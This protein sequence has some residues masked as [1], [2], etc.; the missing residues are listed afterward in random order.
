MLTTAKVT[1][2]KLLNQNKVFNFIP[3]DLE[4]KALG[5]TTLLGFNIVDSLK[6]KMIGLVVLKTLI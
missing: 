6:T 5:T 3:V 4:D 1:K 2:L